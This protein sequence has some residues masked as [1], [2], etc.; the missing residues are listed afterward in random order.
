VFSVNLF[1]K[2]LDGILVGIT[3]DA[4]RILNPG[5]SISLTSNM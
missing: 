1:V 4:I 3:N 5:A 2:P